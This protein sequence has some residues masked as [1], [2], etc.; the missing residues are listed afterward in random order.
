MISETHPRR[1]LLTLAALLL[2]LAAAGS[3]ARPFEVW[4]EGT[5]VDQ[6]GEPLEGVEV[7]ITR[8]RSDSEIREETDPE[9]R[10]RVLLFHADRSH[11]IRLD[12]PGYQSVTQ[13]IP[14]LEASSWDDRE[15]SRARP[16]GNVLE[17]ELAMHSLESIEE[18]ALEA[19]EDASPEARRRA[20]TPI[21]NQGVEAAKSM[22]WVRAEE[23]F[24]KALEIDPEMA[25]AWAALTKVLYERRR[26]QES[27]EVGETARR[28]VPRDLELHEIRIDC[29]R[30]TGESEK[31]WEA[32]QELA[33]KDPYRAAPAFMERAHL[34]YEVPDSEAALPVLERLLE[35]IPDHAEAHHLLGLVLLDLDRP[36]AAREALERYLELDPDADEAEDV[37]AL[38]GA[39]E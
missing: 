21:Y 39:L 26:C 10:F 34:L 31:A 11:T 1:L 12:L 37:R 30:R 9:G 28:L 23:R 7:T 24:R 20:A 17:L 18:G 16:E 3:A 15:K 35:A 32:V 2:G 29:L 5:V 19:P 8:E 6:D 22:L 33:E 25:P 13:P 36:E 27:L 14:A 38:L 4:V